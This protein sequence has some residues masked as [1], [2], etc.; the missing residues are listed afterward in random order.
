[1][2]GAHLPTRRRRI[3]P[4]MAAEA[5]A[6]RVERR[7][8]DGILLL[9]KPPGM[10]S[11]RAL[12]RVKALFRARKAGHTGSLDPL[13]TGMLPIC[14]GEA[15]KVSG[16][17]LDSDKSYRVCLAFGLATSTGDEEGAT[18]AR[19][20]EQVSLE[21]LRAALR[22]FAG[23]YLQVPPM[24]SALKV[25]GQPLYRLARAGLRVERAAREVTIHGLDVEE[26][27]PHRPVLGV[28][29]SK[30][31]Y[32]RTLVEDIACRLGTVAHVLELRRLAVSPF[33]VGTMVTLDRIEQLAATPGADLDALLIPADQAL[34][35]FP[36]LR[37]QAPDVA[38]LRQGRGLQ[39]P[40][41]AAGFVR[42]YGPDG[43]FLGIG[44]AAADGSILSRR[45]WRIPSP[46]TGAKTG[47]TGP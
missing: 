14:L 25:R 5:P 23:P 15:T 46:D 29:C 41:A 44:E 19:G 1:M 47:V 9:D 22:T 34:A 42:L 3:R 10:S 33:P 35:T 2:R 32:I 6:G 24:Y 30:G 37:L 8:V 16:Y 43:L 7:D 26:Y 12:Q 45:L 21:D 36:A 28:R 38:R 39:S 13:A 18:E 31:T 40:G 17:L 27:D 4:K 11:N 20:I